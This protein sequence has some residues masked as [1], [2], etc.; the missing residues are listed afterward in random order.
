MDA[1]ETVFELVYSV[2][3]KLVTINKYKSLR[4][5]ITVFIAEFDGPI[6]EGNFIVGK[7][8]FFFIF[9]KIVKYGI[10][11]DEKNL[12]YK[13]TEIFSIHCTVPKQSGE[14]F[15]IYFRAENTKTH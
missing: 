4:T 3:D 1:S 7:L 13:L 10:F 15:V 5:G 6:V 14:K 9:S 12:P 2:K 8:N 11:F